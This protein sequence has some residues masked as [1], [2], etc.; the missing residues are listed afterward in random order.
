[1][2]EILEFYGVPMEVQLYTVDLEKDQIDGQV[3]G[4]IAEH[5]TAEFLGSLEEEEDSGCWIQKLY[6]WLEQLLVNRFK[7]TGYIK[8]NQ[9]SPTICVTGQIVGELTGSPR[10]IRNCTFGGECT[11]TVLN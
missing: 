5:S 8:S 6:D 3:F 10:F 9:Y 2:V 1:M 4:E 11:T 7:F